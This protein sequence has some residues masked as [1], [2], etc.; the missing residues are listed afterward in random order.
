M[1]QKHIERDELINWDIM[2]MTKAVGRGR[3]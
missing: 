3:D 2:G 1:C